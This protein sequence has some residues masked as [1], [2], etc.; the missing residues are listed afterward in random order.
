MRVTVRTGLNVAK[1]RVLRRASAAHVGRREEQD[2][3]QDRAPLDEAITR[4]EVLGR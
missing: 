1:K 3:W 2:N 4:A